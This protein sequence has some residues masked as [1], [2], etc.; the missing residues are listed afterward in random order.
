MLALVTPF[1]C[2][3]WFSRP[4]ISHWLATGMCPGG[5]MDRPAATC[6]PLEFFSLVFLGGWAAW[7]V[8]PLLC[9]WWLACGLLL[10]LTRHRRS[11]SRHTP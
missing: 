5:P 2:I 8:V 1:L 4:E 7:L 10:W 11:G 3:G 6:G 9:A